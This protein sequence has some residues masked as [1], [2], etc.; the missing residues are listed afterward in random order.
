M[1]P[2]DVQSDPEPEYF[3][4]EEAD[5]SEQKFLASLEAEASR[6]EFVLDDAGGL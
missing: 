3:D 4:P 5:M 2:P 6:P 1:N